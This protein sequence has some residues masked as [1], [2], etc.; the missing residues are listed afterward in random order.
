MSLHS[1]TDAVG[2]VYVGEPCLRCARAIEGDEWI[3][4]WRGP[5]ELVLHQRCARRLALHLIKDS[6][7]TPGTSSYLGA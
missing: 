2:V 1:T 6:F 7:G 3:V 5:H 4:V